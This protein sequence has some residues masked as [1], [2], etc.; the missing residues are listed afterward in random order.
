MVDILSRKM[1]A[2][3]LN[4]DVIT[5][6]Q[7]RA[8]TYGCEL[9]VSDMISNA[10]VLS[11]A[12]LMNKVMEMIIFLAVFTSIRVVCGGHHASSY[13]NCILTFT[14][15]TILIFIV[16]NWIVDRE[17][18]VYPV[19]L[20]IIADI[21]LLIFAP[22]DHPNRPLAEE[23]KIK[24]RKKTI[25]RVVVINAGILFVCAMFPFLAD[26]MI[27]AIMAICDTAISLVISLGEKYLQSN[28][29]AI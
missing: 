28:K 14:S 17:L 10:I 5:K 3:W 24:F 27:Y 13:R 23:E 22:V 1:V 21:I 9:L 20:L 4:Y 2:C 11:A 16:T 26:E 18:Y 15:R 25:T 29:K 19:F 8:Y 7:V 12:F 6:E